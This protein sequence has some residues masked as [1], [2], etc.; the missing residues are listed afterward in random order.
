[1]VILDKWIFILFFVLAG[2][3]GAFMLLVVLVCLF[4]VSVAVDE[5]SHENH[6]GMEMQEER[7]WTGV[8]D[9]TDL[10]WCGI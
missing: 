10:T 8:S 1:M 9:W 4:S 5:H 2:M 6:G 7:V 3:K